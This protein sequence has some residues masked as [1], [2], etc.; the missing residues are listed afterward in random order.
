MWNTGIL[1][2]I[3]NPQNSHDLAIRPAPA[4]DGKA[5]S[6]PPRTHSQESGLAGLRAGATEYAGMLQELEE[7][8]PALIRIFIF[9]CL[10]SIVLDKK[11][12]GLALSRIIPKLD[13]I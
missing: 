13:A 12:K 3:C 7:M 5:R 4:I 1:S 9:S 6:S 11:S 2:F 10:I 8:L